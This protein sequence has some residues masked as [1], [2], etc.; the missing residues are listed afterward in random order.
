MPR[1]VLYRQWGSPLVFTIRANASRQ[2]GYLSATSSLV[3]FAKNEQSTLNIH[4]LTCKLASCPNPR[5]VKNQ[6]PRH[7]R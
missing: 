5:S 2:L 4:D 1:A 3:Y 7:Y 6:N